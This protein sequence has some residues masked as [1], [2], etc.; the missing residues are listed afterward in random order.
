[1]GK[2][3][4]FRFLKALGENNCREW[5][6]L[7]KE[8]YVRARAEFE[9]LLSRI[10]EVLAPDDARFIGVNPKQCIYRIYRDVRFS[11]DKSPYKLNFGAVL[12]P[13]GRKNT[14]PGYY[15]Q[16]EPGKSFFAAGW[17]MPDAES[18]KGVRKEIFDC[19]E[20]FNDILNSPDFVASFDGLSLIG[21]ELK[22]VA[23]GYPKDWEFAHLLRLKHFIVEKTFTD[24][25]VLS[26]DFVHGIHKLIRNSAPLVRFLEDVA[27]K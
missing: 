8:D 23:R 10:F 3:Q 9:E 7:H 5:F 6:T 13:Y 4:I 14:G 20:E 17:Y 16:V 22:T 26:D 11:S 27:G 12:S 18:L 1:M 25:E 2:D 24:E 21:D 19:V 15:L